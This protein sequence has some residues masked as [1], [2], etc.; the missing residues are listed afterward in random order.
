MTFNEYQERAKTTARYPNQ[1]SNITYPTLGLVGE[2]GE[3]ANKVKKIFRDDGGIMTDEKRQEL[4][5]E[6]GDVLWYLSTISTELGFGFEQ[7]AQ[8][9]LEKLAA[10]AA[11]G[12]LHGS[13]DH[14]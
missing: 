2:A 8:A 14:R 12:T 5:S 13:G 10:R 6:A 9:N 11:K 3:I 7:M 1:G 4:L